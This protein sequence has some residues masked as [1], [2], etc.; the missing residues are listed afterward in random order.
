MKYENEEEEK[1]EGE[2]KEKNKFKKTVFV[3]HDS[4]LDTI[5][6]S[7]SNL[8][9]QPKIRSAESEWASELT[10]PNDIV[11]FHKGTWEET[12][13]YSYRIHVYVRWRWR[14]QRGIDDDD[15]DGSGGGGVYLGGLCMCIAHSINAHT[16]HT[17]CVLVMYS[18][19]HLY[20]S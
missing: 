17:L 9:K 8:W 14:W 15:D 5:C 1:V 16:P 4:I 11:E 13:E 6:V 2:R 18:F 19:Y 10:E 7:I 12:Y 3:H 20:I